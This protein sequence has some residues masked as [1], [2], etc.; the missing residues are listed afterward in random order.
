MMGG[1]RLLQQL[2]VERVLLGHLALPPPPHTVTYE[3]L[4]PEA[5]RDHRVADAVRGKRAT[6]IQVRRHVAQ[7]TQPYAGFHVD[8]HRT[9]DQRGQAHPFICKYI[10]GIL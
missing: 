6:Q 1:E 4:E 10:T 7:V 8:K 5:Q 3:G 2:H 9:Q